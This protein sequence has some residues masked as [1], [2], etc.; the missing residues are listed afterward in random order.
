MKQIVKQQWLRERT[1]AV[2]YETKRNK[3]KS[4]SEKSKG[5]HQT[6]LETI[7]NVFQHGDAELVIRY[8]TE[9]ANICDGFT[10]GY[11]A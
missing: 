5:L 7:Y 4:R 8:G 9:A 6:R 3:E 11:P 2:V 1:K 10:G